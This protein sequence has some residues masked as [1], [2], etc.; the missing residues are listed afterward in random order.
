MDKLV[1]DPHSSGKIPPD[2]PFKTGRHPCC[3]FRL[4]LR[5]LPA[6]TLATNLPVPTFSFPL[7]P[8]TPA[9]FPVAPVSGSRE[10]IRGGV[11]SHASVPFP[12]VVFE[13]GMFVSRT[14]L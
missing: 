5:G 14:T 9:S 7:P 4:S 10:C 11:A 1:G 3:R 2:T 12:I 6:G 8:I 13:Y